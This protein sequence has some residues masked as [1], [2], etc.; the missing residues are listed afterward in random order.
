LDLAALVPGEVLK[1]AAVSVW[2]ASAAG[3]VSVLPPCFK[4]NDRGGG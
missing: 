4:E 3:V 2:S 1:R